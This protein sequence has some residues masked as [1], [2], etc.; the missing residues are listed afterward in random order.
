M[1]KRRGPPRVVFQIA[2]KLFAERAVFLRSKIRRLQ[3]LEGGH[4]G[5]RHKTPPE[6]PE[7]AFFLHDLA[8]EMN[9]FIFSMSFL[10]GWPSFSTPLAASTPSASV[11]STASFTLSGV[12]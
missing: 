9:S 6:G 12:K 1:E 4:Q 11:E 8:L 7:M 3:L 10:R 2:V 5:L